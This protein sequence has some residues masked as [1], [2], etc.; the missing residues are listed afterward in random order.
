MGL[1]PHQWLCYEARGAS[2]ASRASA[3]GKQWSKAVL[4]PPRCAGGQLLRLRLLV[5][6]MTVLLRLWLLLCLLVWSVAC[7]YGCGCACVCCW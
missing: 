7:C 4:L 2:G 1:T 6:R 3:Q 5:R